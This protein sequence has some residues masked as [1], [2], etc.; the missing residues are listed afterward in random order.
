MN[1]VCVSVSLYIYFVC[2]YKCGWI[3]NSVLWLLLELWWQKSW[4]AAKTL[5]QRMNRKRLHFLRSSLKLLTCPT[6]FTQR[7][8]R[9]NKVIIALQ[10]LTSKFNSSTGNCTLYCA[11][12]SVQPGSFSGFF[13]WFSQLFLL[14]QSVCQ[15]RSLLPCFTICEAV[16]E[17]DG[18]E[19]SAS[20]ILDEQTLTC[21]KRTWAFCLT[22]LSEPLLTVRSILLLRFLDEFFTPYQ[23]VW[24]QANTMAYI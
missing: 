20:K 17:A 5:P 22:C 8:G 16:G 1:M 2:V 6:A 14:T 3:E 21:V 11:M 7:F 10:I 24:A 18:Q 15:L 4:N 9:I 23:S 12:S 13:L 19:I